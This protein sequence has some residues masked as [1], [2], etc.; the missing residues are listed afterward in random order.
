MEAVIDGL[1]GLPAPARVEAAPAGDGPAPALPGGPTPLAI[2][3]QPQAT[4]PQDE[5]VTPAAPP[6]RPPWIAALLGFLSGSLLLGGAGLLVWM[7][8]N[9][10]PSPNNNHSN[11]SNHVNH[12]SQQINNLWKNWTKSIL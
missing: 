8:N 6:S 4:A 9:R 3:P 10:I 12:P 5:L 2:A 7:L 11:H 1:L